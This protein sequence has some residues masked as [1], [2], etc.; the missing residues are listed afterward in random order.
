[1]PPLAQAALF[2]VVLWWLSTGVV[3]YLDGLPRRTFRWSL[4][5]AT[6]LLV[7]SLF[8]LFWSSAHPTAMG[9]AAAF[10]SAIGAWSWV[11]L[12]F[13]LGVVTGP[14]RIRCPQD[15]HGWK[16]FGHA[17]GVSLYH[18]IAAIVLLLVAAALTWRSPNRI[19]LYALVALWVMHESARINV[20]LGVRNVGE[21]FV[22]AHLDFL[23]S[24]LRQRPM[25]ALFPFSAAAL[26]VA[27]GMLLAAALSAHHD[28]FEAAGN[29][30]LATLV[31]LG[32]LEHW[33][34]IV[35]LP[36]TG[37]WNFWMRLRGRER[38]A[39]APLS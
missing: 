31:G 35:P 3:L 1:M 9:A 12:T 34:L 33:L 22:P 23:K 19:G 28:P 32:L 26:S 20:F 5:G 2:A 4:F 6:S 8:G 30:L 29:M 25:N 11:E 39:T 21:S 17:L 14:R 7:A 18:E 13:Y 10:G 37:L 16:H 36:L 27:F 24:F 38:P 15:C